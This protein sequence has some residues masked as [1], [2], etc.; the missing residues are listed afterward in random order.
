MPLRSIALVL[1]A[2]LLCLAIAWAQEAPAVE[3]L[4]ARV[5]AEPEDG[6]AWYALGR[7]LQEGEDWDAALAAFDRAIALGFQRA[8]AWMRSA[9]IH[10]AKGNAGEALKI[11]EATA[12]TA[13]AVLA[14]LPQIGGIP[15]LEGDPRLQAIL[16]RAEAAR[17]PCRTRPESRQLDF[18]IGEWTVSDPA[19]VVVG[20]NVITSDLEGCVLRESWT[21]GYGGRGT[22][23]NVYDPATRLWHQVWTSDNGTVNHY[24][25]EW[26][27]G[28][29]RFVAQGFGDA[30]GETRHRRMTFTPHPDG[31]VRQRIEES[32]DGTTWTV[33]FDG[34]YR[35]TTAQPPS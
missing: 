4:Q 16:A 17:Y 14:L 19:G 27:D 29:M 8:G 11:L 6:G 10:A 31:S 13:P 30:D 26:R 32:E 3:E 12:E 9:Q 22:S 1:L 33:G 28:S 21:D 25:G 35:R 18:W 5:E 20:E 15:A 24:Q 7:A 23:V 34:L 2:T